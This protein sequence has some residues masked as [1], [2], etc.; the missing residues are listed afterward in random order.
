M[1]EIRFRFAVALGALWG[2][3]WL[4]AGC[5]LS[6]PSEEEV[7]AEFDGYVD[8][9]N[10]CDTADECA[11]ASAGC[12]LG[13]QVAVRKERVRDVE[14][15]AR[16]LIDDYESAGRSCDYGCVQPLGVTCRAGRCVDLTTE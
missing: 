9:A 3:S 10:A 7:R 13:C 12:P 16:E 4:V 15:K 14:K 2:T 8:G 6:A 11:Y 1:V 5:A